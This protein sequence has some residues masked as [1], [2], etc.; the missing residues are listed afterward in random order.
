MSDKEL[1]KQYKNE[2]LAEHL[3]FMPLTLVD[4]VIN[5]INEL[6]YQATT[7]FQDFV[8]EHQGAGDHT[9]TGMSQLET[10]LE[11]NIDYYFDIFELYTLNHILSLPDNLPIILPHYKDIVWE[12]TPEDP[13][14][15]DATLNRARKTLQNTMMVN[16]VAKEQIPR[17]DQLLRRIELMDEKVQQIV[18]ITAESDARVLG[19]E[20]VAFIA[21]Q[22]AQLEH[23]MAALQSM[24]EPAT[25]QA[26]PVPPSTRDVYLDVAT[27]T[28]IRQRKA[29]DRKRSHRSTRASAIPPADGAAADDGDDDGTLE[30]AEASQCL[31][32]TQD[33]LQQIATLDSIEL[34]RDL[35]Q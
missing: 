7:I 18:T 3:G 31:G 20:E 23:S 28:A 22:A 33:Q 12:E 4:D 16:R 34:A 15:L 11:H 24:A 32:Q 29:M 10:I 2:L 25:W 8:E 19:E 6:L 17:L 5:A 21:E 13:K 26:Q 9:E 1:Q 30:E 35:L 27:R 14:E